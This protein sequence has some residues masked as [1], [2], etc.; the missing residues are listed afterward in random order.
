MNIF[1]LN[2]QYLLQCCCHVKM[3]QFVC[4]AALREILLGIFVIILLTIKYCK[5]EGGGK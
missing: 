4:M 3:L 1:K 5:H 2:Q